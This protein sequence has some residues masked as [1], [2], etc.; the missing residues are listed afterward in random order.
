MCL[1]TDQKEPTIAKTDLTTY[2]VLLTNLV[3]PFEHF[4]YELGK[5]YEQKISKSEHQSAYDGYDMGY[6]ER[7]Y[8]SFDDFNNNVLFFGEGLH[9]SLNIERLGRVILGECIF[10]CKVP[11]GAEYY[12]GHDGLIVSN[13][14]TILEKI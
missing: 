11:K 2:K 1:I 9:S 6:Y 5:E 8:Y 3:S 13:K 7:K 14:L 12:E 4:Q 10:K